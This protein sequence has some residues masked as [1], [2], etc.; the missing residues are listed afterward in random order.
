MWNPAN[1]YHNRQRFI[2]NRTRPRVSGRV[3]FEGEDTLIMEKIGYSWLNCVTSISR[4]NTFVKR[5]FVLDF[6][7]T[8]HV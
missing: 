2:K 5:I 7:S 8:R 1:A 3:W 6:M 4:Q